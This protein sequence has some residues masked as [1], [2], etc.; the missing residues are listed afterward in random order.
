ML[1]EAYKREYRQLLINGDGRLFLEK[2]LYYDS[3]DSALAAMN[4]ENVFNYV[5]VFYSPV[6][7]VW[8]GRHLF[9]AYRFL[10]TVFHKSLGFADRLCLF[11][12]VKTSFAGIWLE[13]EENSDKL[14]LKVSTNAVNNVEEALQQIEKVFQISVVELKRG[15]AESMYSSWVDRMLEVA[16]SGGDVSISSFIDSLEINRINRQLQADYIT[17]QRRSELLSKKKSILAKH[18]GV[19]GFWSDQVTLNNR[20]IEALPFNESFTYNIPSVFLLKSW[21]SVHSMLYNLSKYFS[22]RICFRAKEWE[23]IANECGDIDASEITRSVYDRIEQLL[24]KTLLMM[25]V[26]L[27]TKAIK[28]SGRD[29]AIVYKNTPGIVNEWDFVYDAQI[30]IGVYSESC[31]IETNKLHYN[32]D[33]NR[34]SYLTPGYYDEQYIDTLLESQKFSIVNTLGTLTGHKRFINTYSLLKTIAEEE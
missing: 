9:I 16:L 7:H 13:K 34:F 1:I 15:V 31:I 5:L 24:I 12:R 21:T 17:V 6:N 8:D 20:E 4:S 26:F 25:K 19:E 23:E 22:N 18:I 33:D 10:R 28:R 32:S 29:Y 2:S 27:T 3:L 14:C 11:E 30:I